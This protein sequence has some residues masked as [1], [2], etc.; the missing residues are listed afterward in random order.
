[1]LHGHEDTPAMF[2][3]FDVL[4]A[5]GDATL[6]LPYRQRRAILESLEFQGNHWAT[7]S[8]DED[9]PARP[10]TRPAPVLYE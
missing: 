10:A 5:R 2:I 4:H 9:V 6:R 8:S 1:M 3:A 7:G